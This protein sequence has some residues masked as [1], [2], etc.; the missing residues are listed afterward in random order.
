MQYL[1][2]VLLLM[3]THFSLSAFVPGPVAHYYWPWAKDSRPSLQILDR[4][5][6]PV[7]SP[8]LAAAAGIAFV[9][10]LL[11]LFGLIP[12]SWW[13]PL[14][15]TGCTASGLQFLGYLGPFA[16]LPLMVDAGLLFGLFVL[17]WSVADLRG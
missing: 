3:G 11:A 9:G 2:I 8:F 13:L 15:V 7:F 16:T 10:A 12:E 6:R 17:R 1:V 4:A 5:F 14:V